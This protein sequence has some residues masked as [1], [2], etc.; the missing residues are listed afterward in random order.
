M[1][2]A[3]RE[4]RRSW[5][6]IFLVALLL[7]AAA[8]GGA[9]PVAHAAGSTVGNVSLGDFNSGTDGWTAFDGVEFDPNHLAQFSFEQDTTATEGGNDSGRLTGNFSQGGQYV[10][11]QKTLSQL[12][13]NQLSFWVQAP[14]ASDVVLRLVDATGQTHQQTLAL[15]GSGWQKLTVTDFTAGTY[16]G[17]ADDGVWHGPA[18]GI[19]LILD[20]Q[21]MANPSQP[22]SMWFADIEG[23]EP[24]PPVTIKQVK[25][26][27]VFENGAPARFTIAT[28]YDGISWYV[29]DDAGA[30][31][32]QGQ[33]AVP[34]PSVPLTIR[35]R[36]RG[37]FTL[38]VTALNQGQSA[39]TAETSFALLSGSGQADLSGSPFGVS[40]HFGEA[41]DPASIPLIDEAGIGNTRDELYWSNIET[42]A[43]V[44]TYPAQYDTYMS[45]L[46]RHGLT[47][48]II[49]DYG[50]PLYDGGNAPTSVAGRQAYASYIVHL[51]Q[52]Y[53]QLHEI[54]IWN[55]YNIG[56]GG[57]DSSPADYF[58]MLQVAYAA[59]K[60]VRPDVTVVGAV[61]SGVPLTWLAQLFQLGGLKYMDAVSIHPYAYPSPP[62]GLDSEV[63]QVES[64]I[65]QNNGGKPMPVWITED[66]WPTN[67]GSGGVD[68]STQ[69][70]YLVRAAVLALAGGA[71]RF[72]WYD[73]MNDGTDPTDNEDNFGIIRNADDPMG[74]YTPKPA[75][76]AYAVLA[77]ELAGAQLVGEE[78]Q[79]DSD[80]Y[81]VRFNRGGTPVRVLWS[82]DGSKDLTIASSSPL[83][84]VDS[85]GN[86]RTLEPRDGDV[87]LTVSG[88]PLYLIGPA[89][90][91]SEGARIGV[92]LPATMTPADTSLPATLTLDNTGI[93]HATPATFTIAGH[94][95]HLTAL[96]GQRATET[97]QVPTPAIEQGTD[98]LSTTVTLAGHPAGWLSSQIDLTDQA[99]SVSQVITHITSTSPPQG[100][101]LVT[102]RNNQAAS[103]LT[104]SQVSWTV[105]SSSGSVPVTQQVAPNATAQV[106]VPVG[107]VTFEAISPANVTAQAGGGVSANWQGQAV[108]SPLIERSLGSD[109]SPSQV[110]SDP[111]VSVPEDGQWV[112]LIPSQP[113]GGA[114]DLSGQ[115]WFNWDSQALYVTAVVHDSTF[116]QPYTGDQIWDGDSIQFSVAPGAPAASSPSYQYGMALTPDGPQIYCWDAPAG[117]ATGP[118]TNAQLH[119][120]RDASTGDT[121][122]LLALPWQDLTPVTASVGTIMSL[123]FLINDN[124]GN[125]RKG[126][127]QWGS[128]I[129]FG[130]DPSQFNQVQLL[131][132]PTS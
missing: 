21:Y 98:T 58:A 28:P 103:P 111:S 44:Y 14:G 63:G 122:Y 104:L 10:G 80:L 8:V 129:G 4:V 39:G 22:T 126:W 67:T 40:T 127:M 13:L 79:S 87:Y 100:S 99:L 132:P 77:R 114:S 49:A 56:S 41:W 17:G 11:I 15:S 123:S 74:A 112:S 94:R 16:Y 70:Q 38:H 1:Q 34:G 76:V 9:A 46:Q 45:S 60:A 71:S 131:G 110:A 73:F 6:P 95:Y 33:T 25:L 32:A 12:N 78:P 115:L 48:L 81:S 68:E 57:S 43:G 31:V 47:P 121:T 125:G 130:Q 72:F 118:V 51:L 85:M 124:N 26:G 27:N 36:E 24:T 82:A 35:L 88:S 101:L 64:L 42:Q 117:V 18:T 113:Y 3:R 50:N 7:V 120:T 119:I 59:I 2:M 93:A 62:E 109:W 105:G 65:K 92:S 29:D 30:R 106:T 90:A 89:T 52:H 20:K 91:I 54:E 23:Q 19:S 86:Q 5:I 116:Y 66:G 84:V 107:Q 53:P 128:G 69:A 75:Y 108:F 83:T 102:V 97:V 55:E 96:P 61:T 37:Y